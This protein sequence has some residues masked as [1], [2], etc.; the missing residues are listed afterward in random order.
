VRGREGSTGVVHASGTPWVIARTSRDFVRSIDTPWGGDLGFDY[1]FDGN[2]SAPPSGWAWVNQGSAT[3]AERYGLGGIAL[4]ASASM[5][6]RSIVRSLSGA[7]STWQATMK[8]SGLG[9]SANYSFFGMT[10]RN[11]SAG[12]QVNLWLDSTSA[13]STQKL[14][15]ATTLNGSPTYTFVA[16]SEPPRTL[17]FR[18]TK[19]SATSWDFHISS[20]GV[21]WFPVDLARDV[22]GHLTPDEI[23]FIGNTQNSLPMNVACHWFRL[24]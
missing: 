10:L 3:Y 15:N 19:N 2:L 18:I 14:D 9:G 20:S 8:L 11:N 5:S 1:E 22:S 16:M 12:T 4:P 6:T 23:G 21:V 24:R 17:L 7:P 13:I